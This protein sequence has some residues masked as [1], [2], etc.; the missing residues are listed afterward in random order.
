MA[1]IAPAPH[2]T[3]A[4]QLV[5]KTNVVVLSGILISLFVAGSL[6]DLSISQALYSPGNRLGTFLAAYGEIPAFLAWASSGTLFFM[7]RNVWTVPVL[8][9]LQG[10]VG[11]VSVGVAFVG[12]TVIPLDYGDLSLFWTAP[13]ALVLV[14]GV[15]ATTWNLGRE[16]DDAFVTRV[17]VVLF[18][19]PFLEMII[20]GVVKIF[21]ER[22]RMRMLTETEGAAFMSWWQ[23]GYPQREMLLEQ[24]VLGEEFKSFPSGH[25]SNAATLMLL[26]AW[27]ALSA[28]LRGR[29]SWLFWLGAAWAFLVA[30][31][32]ITMGAH[33]LTDTVAGFSVT[34]LVLLAVYAAA[35]QRAPDQH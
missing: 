1:H 32:R 18:L 23:P 10:F 20:V 29:V 6:W 2:T 11:V 19:V 5:P 8:R 22:P 4:D 31:S 33:F 26:T 25:T 35:F 34:F 9:I 14:G 16:V 21:W 24:G 17:A 12:G 30:F 28:K 3:T 7:G 15:V 13:V 27:A